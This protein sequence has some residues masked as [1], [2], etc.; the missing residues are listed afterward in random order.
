MMNLFSGQG[1]EQ[2]EVLKVC[3]CGFVS[4]NAEI[5]KLKEQGLWKEELE[6]TGL[7]N[8]AVNSQS[9]KRPVWEE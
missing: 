7:E 1:L 3:V 4:Q 6:P 8:Q 5:E 9:K 2:K